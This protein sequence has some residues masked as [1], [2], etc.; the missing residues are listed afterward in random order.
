MNFQIKHKYKF[1][2][3]KGNRVGELEKKDEGKGKFLTFERC[4][5]HYLQR[6]DPTKVNLSFMETFIV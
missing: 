5:I 6:Q 4:A 1:S 2:R 3:I